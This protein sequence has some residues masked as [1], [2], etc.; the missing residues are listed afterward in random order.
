MGMLPSSAQPQEVQHVSAGKSLVLCKVEIAGELVVHD[1]G[2]MAVSRLRVLLE[3]GP[4]NFESGRLN[5]DTPLRGRLSP[6]T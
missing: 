4:V 6:T 1:S 3:I 5:L 2:K